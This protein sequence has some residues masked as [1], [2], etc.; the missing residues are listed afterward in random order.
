MQQLTTD[1]AREVRRV[2]LKL[3]AQAWGTSFG[4]I[5]GVGL[6][7][8]TAVLVMRGGVNVGE[9]L[10]LLAVYFPGYR[11]TWLGACIG[12]VYAFVLGYAIGR[13]VG[14]AY[15]AIAFRRD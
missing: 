11:V 7:I 1:E 4:M 13:V 2:I 5:L 3:N 14:T 9:H 12:F 15:N 10:G 6:F 8:A